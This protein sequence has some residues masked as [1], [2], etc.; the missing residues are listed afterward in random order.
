MPPVHHHRECRRAWHRREARGD[1]RPG[2]LRGGGRLR[3]GG[4]AVHRP[5]R[6]ARHRGP[7]RCNRQEMAAVMITK[8]DKH[9]RIV[10]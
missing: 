8:Q 4:P 10:F 7:A 9:P 5:L 1:A 3:P 6:D 2:R